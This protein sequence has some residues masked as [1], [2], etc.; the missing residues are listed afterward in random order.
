MVCGYYAFHQLMKPESRTRNMFR[1]IKF[2]R[3]LLMDT[4]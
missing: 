4:G 2:A 1:N 3:K